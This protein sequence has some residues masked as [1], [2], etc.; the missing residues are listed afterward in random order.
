MTSISGYPARP[1]V[2]AGEVLRLHIAA[3]APRFH[4]D[5]YRWGRRPT[6]RAMSSGPAAPPSPARSTRTGG[7]PP[8]SSS[9]PRV[10][11]RGLHRDAEHG[12]DIGHAADGLP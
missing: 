11:V 6:T 3:S 12:A 9:C 8:T 7:G 5:F 1:S 4:V 2:R 10:E